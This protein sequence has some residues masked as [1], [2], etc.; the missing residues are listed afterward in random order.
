MVEC[1]CLNLPSV[2]TIYSVGTVALIGMRLIT[3]VC[4]GGP[5]LRA[6]LKL[7]YAYIY[8][9]VCVCVCVYV[10]QVGSC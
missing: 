8:M 6:V 10:L 1:E 7:S 3:S 4:V 2:V 9:C 5:I